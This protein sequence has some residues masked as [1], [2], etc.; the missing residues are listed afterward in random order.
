MIKAINFS[1]REAPGRQ[2]TLRS[3][4]SKEYSE[5]TGN[6]STIPYTG[7]WDDALAEAQ[8]AIDSAREAEDV[9]CELEC[10]EGGFT[11]LRITREAFRKPTENGEEEEPDES[12]QPEGDPGDNEDNPTSTCSSS[13]VPIPLLAH[14]KFEGI[15]GDELRALKAMM[16][17]Q[18]E[19]AF[20]DTN[21]AL[22]ANKTITECI[23]SEAGLK[24]KEYLSKGVTSPNSSSTEAT[25]RWKGRSN[26]Y[27]INTIY[28]SIPN[29]KA[30]AGCNWLCS[31]TGTEKNGS[32]VW[33]TASFRL[34]G[35]GGWDPYLYD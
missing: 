34:S 1:L 31:G 19:N 7:P 27:E 3:S 18:D 16:D 22:G 25:L 30:K 20:L 17:G 11:E 24:A 14:P 26:S 10:L 9:T 35:P 33:Q 6:R 8:A 4:P 21:A 29:V 23:T 13:L 2:T 28:S 15:A 12:D 32:E 5:S